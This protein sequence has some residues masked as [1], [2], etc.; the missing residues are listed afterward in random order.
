MKPLPTLFIASAAFLL[1][2]C[3]SSTKRVEIDRGL[4]QE[5]PDLP[6]VQVAADGTA[7]MGDLVLADIDAAGMYRECQAGKKGLIKAIKKAGY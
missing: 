6:V 5:C 7:S 4:M 2:G 3:S 1:L